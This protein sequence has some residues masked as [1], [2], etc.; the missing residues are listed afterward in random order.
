M[1]WYIPFLL[2]NIPYLG[3]CLLPLPSFSTS[4]F[5]LSSLSSFH[6]RLTGTSQATITQKKLHLWSIVFWI[7]Y[8][9]CKINNPKP[10]L[11]LLTFLFH[12]PC[13]KLPTE[14][15]L[16]LQPSSP[17]SSLAGTQHTPSQMLFLIHSTFCWSPYLIDFTSKMSMEI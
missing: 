17:F 15:S 5:K 7:S 6:Q 2:Q 13:S 1:S 3:L 9:T 11:Y 4:P 12:A 16:L 14:G 8:K 10:C